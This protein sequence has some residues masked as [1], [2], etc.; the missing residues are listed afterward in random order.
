MK[1]TKLALIGALAISGAAHAATI[2]L[3]LSHPVN[4]QNSAHVAMVKFADLV[5][6]KTKGEVQISVFPNSMLGNN[7]QVQ[8]LCR[9]GS[10]DICADAPATFMA[11]APGLG[12]LEVPFTFRDS[13][14]A[15][16]VLDGEIGSKLLEELGKSQLKGL[17]F[18]EGGWRMITNNKRPVQTP[19]DLK[20]LKI[21][22]N[23]SPYLDAAFKSLGANPGFLNIGELYSALETK[24]YDAQENPSSVYFGNKLFEVQKYL[25]LSNHGYTAFLIGMNKAKFDSLPASIQKVLLESVREAAD[26]Q[27]KS[28][29]QEFEKLLA[30]AKKAGVQV[31]DKPNMAPFLNGAREAVRQTFKDKGGN[32]AVLD[33]IEAVK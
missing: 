27:R 20:G 8:S 1:L 21:R 25:T 4:P 31:V 32:L 18:M 5:K 15:Y 30:D 29:A 6:E 3:K 28:N 14:H 12:A 33:A 7:Q 26:F 2:T 22:T 23:G 11:V 19:D 13:A 24:A 16:K 10:I 9:S 17:G